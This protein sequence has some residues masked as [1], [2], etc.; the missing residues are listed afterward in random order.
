MQLRP[1]IVVVDDNEMTGELLIFFLSQR[2]YVV[3][4]FSNPKKA[5]EYLKTNLVN[6]M[7]TDIQMPEMNGIELIKKAQE[8]NPNLPIIAISGSFNIKIIDRLSELYITDYLQ[9]PFK[10]NHIENIIV[11]KLG[12]IFPLIT[13]HV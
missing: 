12:K 9:K 4:S 13:Q 6:L 5:L 2:G 7:I 3:T 8:L 11:K 10:L 1:K